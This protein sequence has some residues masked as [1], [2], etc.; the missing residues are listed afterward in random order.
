MKSKAYETYNLEEFDEAIP[1]KIGDLVEVV[2]INNTGLGENETDWL[3]V[4]RKNV[5]KS[6]SI[7][8]EFEFGPKC[9]KA[10]KSDNN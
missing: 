8:S 1:Y 5:G 6:T 3:K 4:I 2:F 7:D 9:V 10:V